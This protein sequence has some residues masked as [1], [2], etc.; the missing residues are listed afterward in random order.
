MGTDCSKTFRDLGVKSV[1]S[2]QDWQ[3]SMHAFVG[4]SDSSPL[5]LFR[6]VLCHILA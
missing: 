2:E 5:T 3:R 1:P 6:V 4:V